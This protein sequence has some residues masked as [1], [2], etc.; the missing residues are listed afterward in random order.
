MATWRQQ[1]ANI[2]AQAR[3]GVSVKETLAIVRSSRWRWSDDN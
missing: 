2:D 3:S 1:Q